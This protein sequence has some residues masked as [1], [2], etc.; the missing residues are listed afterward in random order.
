[1]VEYLVRELG[2]DRVLF[3]TDCVMRD[4]APQL[5]WAAWARI[6]LQDKRMVLGGNMADILSW[7]AERRASVTAT[8]REEAGA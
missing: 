5:G 2:R 1:M 8:I 4:V 7:P 3:G 6:P